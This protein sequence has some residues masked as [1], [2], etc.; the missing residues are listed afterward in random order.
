MGGAAR[1]RGGRQQVVL[2]P[3]PRRLHPLW[4]LRRGLRRRPADRRHRAA[5]A[6]S[7]DEGRCLRRRIDGVVGVYLVRPV[8]GHVPDRR[9]APQGHARQ[10]RPRRR[11]HVPVLRRGLRHRAEGPRRRPPGDHGGRCAGEPLE[12]RHAVRQG[13][14]RDGLRARARSRDPAH[15]QARRPLARGRLGRS[16]RRHGRGPRAPPRSLRCPREREGDQRR[17]LPRAEILSRRHGH[18][19]RGP[20]HAAVPLALG[21]GDARVHGLGR[22][23]ELVPGLRG[24]GLPHGRR[25]RR[26][27]QSSGHRRAL[28]ARGE[29]RRAARRRQSQRHRALRAGRSLDRPAPRHRRGP[30]PSRRSTA[31]AGGP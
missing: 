21:G 1:L 8:R 23:L 30:R 3:R 31:P 10:D 5:R 15:G 13:P 16:A 7:R 14:V 27:G 12:S 26:V 6:Q 11:D 29:P 17:R 25:R 20:L 28:A 2:R 4:P 18:E 19:R 9:A 22:H 24:G